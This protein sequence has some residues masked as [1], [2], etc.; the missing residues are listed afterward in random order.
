VEKQNSM[1]DDAK[2]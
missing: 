2:S 1:H